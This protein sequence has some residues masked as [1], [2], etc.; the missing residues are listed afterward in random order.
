MSMDEDFQYIVTKV[1]QKAQKLVRRTNNWNSK[2]LSQTNSQPI[3]SVLITNV[4]EDFENIVN[5]MVPMG[6]KV[7]SMVT[8]MIKNWNCTD[9]PQNWGWKCF[10]LGDYLYEQ[11][12]GSNLQQTA[13]SGTHNSTMA[14]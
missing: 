12:V 9:W 8:K 2:R 14:K 7:E 1:M 5:K 6:Q 4:G 10:K 11:R 3:P 13:L